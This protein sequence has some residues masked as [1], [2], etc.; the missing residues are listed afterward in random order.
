MP[1]LPDIS[2][3]KAEENIE[4]PKQDTSLDDVKKKALD[5][6]KGLIDKIELPAE[7]RFEIYR[8]LIENNGD[9]SCIGKAYEA[10]QAISD[11]NERAKA[12]IFVVDSINK[13]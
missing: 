13:M 4:E 9:K 1:P 2:G 10:A 11:E 12:L 8:E 5:D 7:N 3:S 6:L